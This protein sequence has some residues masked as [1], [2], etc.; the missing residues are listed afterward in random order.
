MRMRKLEKGQLIM[1]CEFM[2]VERKILHDSDKSR[3]D[4]IEIVDVLQ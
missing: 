4:I 1:F 2:K 3:C